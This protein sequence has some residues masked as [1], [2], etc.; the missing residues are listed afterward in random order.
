MRHT[1]I[2]LSFYKNDFTLYGI[3]YHCRIKD[4]L[5]IINCYYN[6]KYFILSD[7]LVKIDKTSVQLFDK[8]LI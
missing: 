8:L 7:F 5:F 4:N 1:N 2:V 3:V 6:Q